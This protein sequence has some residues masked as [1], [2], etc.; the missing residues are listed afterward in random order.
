MATQ[1]GIMNKIFTFIFRVLR[2]KILSCFSHDVDQV[3]LDLHWRSFSN[4]RLFGAQLIF[5]VEG[6]LCYGNLLSG[7]GRVKVSLAVRSEPKGTQYKVQR[8][9]GH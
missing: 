7:F 8:E 1:S 2:N 3:R 4:S 9:D 6:M 5:D